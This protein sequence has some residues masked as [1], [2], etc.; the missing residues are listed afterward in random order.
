MF[1]STSVHLCSTTI[2]KEGNQTI[3]QEKEVG[4]KKI[5]DFLYIKSLPRLLGKTEKLNRNRTL[6]PVNFWNFYNFSCL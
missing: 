6:T 3:T 5:K 2:E 1:L 4:C